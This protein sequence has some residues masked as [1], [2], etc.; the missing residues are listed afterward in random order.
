MTSAF[1]FLRRACLLLLLVLHRTLA[2]ST[3]H[4]INSNRNLTLYKAK[5]KAAE[6]GHSLLKKKSDALTG[7]FRSILGDI[8]DVCGAGWLAT[9]QDSH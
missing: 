3:I 1:R 8:L 4:T 7:R 9:G 2:C 5:L 6:R